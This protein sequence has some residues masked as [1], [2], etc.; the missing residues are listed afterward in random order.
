MSTY[1]IFLDWYEEQTYWWFAYDVIKN[2]TMQ[3][4]N[5][6]GPMKTEFQTKEVRE[7]SIMLYGSGG[8]R[9]NFGWVLSQR[10]PVKNGIFVHFYSNLEI[11]TRFQKPSDPVWSATV[12][13][14]GLVGTLLPTNMAAAIQMYGDFLNFQKQL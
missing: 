11:L 12:W 10:N 9:Q 4:M 6:F 13:E 14:N 5:F 7:F 3:I 8:S 2:M 1:L